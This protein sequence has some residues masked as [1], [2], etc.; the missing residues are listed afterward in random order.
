DPAK[1]EYYPIVGVTYWTF[2]LMMGLGFW[3]FGVAPLVLQPT[4]GRPGARAG[5]RPGMMDGMADRKRKRKR[6]AGTTGAPQ[7]PTATRTVPSP[8]PPPKA[9]GN[10]A[11]KRGYA[12]AELKNIAAREALEPIGPE[13]RPRIVLIACGWLLL[14]CISL[15]VSIITADGDGANATRF[16]N[17]LML[18]V[19]LVA[20][21]GTYRLRPWAILGAQTLFALA[22]VF[23]ILAAVFSD[24][25]LLSV[26]LVVSGLITGWVFYRMINV[27][28]RVQKMELIRRGELEGTPPKA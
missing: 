5:P 28:A 19:V 8:A 24:K 6:H 4:A 14:A 9:G 11:M 27:M 26:G 3:M 2:R 22:F 10:D 18:I 17:A 16:G 15:I 23:T 7:K 12:K 20:V 21:W 13:N 1:A 25:A